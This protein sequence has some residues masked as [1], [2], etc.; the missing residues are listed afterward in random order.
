M[1]KLLPEE[2]RKLLDLSVELFIVCDINNRNDSDEANQIEGQLE[3]LYKRTSD[4]QRSC[5]NA[6]LGHV[7]EWAEKERKTVNF[8]VA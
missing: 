7:S 3:D 2:M 5:F 8:E 6:V 1:K 4:D